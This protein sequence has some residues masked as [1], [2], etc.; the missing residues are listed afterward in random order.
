MIYTRVS[1]IIHLPKTNQRHKCSVRIVRGIHVC[2][3]LWL[4]RLPIHLN[5]KAFRYQ[6]ISSSTP[7]VYTARAH[8]VYAPS[9][10]QRAILCNP[11]SHWLGAY[12]E[13][14]LHCM[15]DTILERDQFLG[16]DMGT[17]CEYMEWT[18][19]R[20]FR[21]KL[22]ATC[23]ELTVYFGNHD[24][25]IMP[26]SIHWRFTWIPMFTIIKEGIYIYEYTPIRV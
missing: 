17:S 18:V 10:W 4:R 5:T 8:S 12:I 9:Q 23:L 3:T 16:S 19:L 14:L 1:R 11:I 6:L 13:W 21:R 2:W 24:W 26:S 15:L 22:S 20:I 7:P 25:I